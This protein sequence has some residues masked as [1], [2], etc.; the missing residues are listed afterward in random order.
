[1]QHTQTTLSVIRRFNRGV[2]LIE[3]M[4]VIVILA[5][6]AAVGIPAMGQ[7]TK[8]TRASNVTNEFVNAVSTARTEA[9]RR[10]RLVTVCRSTTPEAALPTCDTG[11][12]WS[13]GWVVFVET[14]SAAPNTVT[15][16]NLL[17]R[18]GVL[19]TNVNA[20]ELVKTIPI[21]FNATGEPVGNFTGVSFNFNYN[22]GCGRQVDIS[23]TGRVTVTPDGTPCGN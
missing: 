4:I 10:G 3:A 2:T 1:M 23:R 21:T 13:P 6:L 8:D 12:D 22:G 20:Q 14:S 18:H 7:F 19:T 17:S 9:I 5:I 11:S 15:A 16:A